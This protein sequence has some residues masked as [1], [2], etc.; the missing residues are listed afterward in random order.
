MTTWYIWGG[1]VR[2]S[3]FSATTEPPSSSFGGVTGPTGRFE[4]GLVAMNFIL[5]GGVSHRSLQVNWWRH[6]DI[7]A[8]SSLHFPRIFF[9][10]VFC[11]AS[12]AA[13]AFAGGAARK[14]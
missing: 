9:A 7:Q 8:S 12:H 14:L 3:R 1:L 6:R 11:P 10:P 5:D 4:G 13:H 2:W